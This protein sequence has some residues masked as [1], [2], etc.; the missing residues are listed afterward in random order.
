MNRDAGL[1]PGEIFCLTQFEPRVPIHPF[2]PDSPPVD[3]IS[4]LIGRIHALSNSP[5]GP[6]VGW[7]IF[8]V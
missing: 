6:A 3:G 5:I 1:E 7:S 8:H 4:F 2:S